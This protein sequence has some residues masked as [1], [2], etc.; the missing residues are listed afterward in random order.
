[1]YSGADVS[2][3]PRPIYRADGRKIPDCYTTPPE[4]RERL[5]T[6]LGRFPL[7]NFWGPASSIVSSRWIAEASRIVFEHHRPTLSL[8]YLPHLDY[9][10]QRLGPGHPALADA[11]RDIDEVVGGLIDFFEAR[12]VRLIILS[13]YG[14]EAVSGDVPI[15]R[16]LREAGGC[17]SGRRWAASCST[18]GRA[19]PLPWPI[20]RWRTSTSRRRTSNALRRSAANSRASSAV[21]D[22][23]EQAAFGL[24]HPRAGE[25]VL[26]AARG[27]WFSYPYWLDDRRAPDFAR[28]V[29]IHRKPGYDPLELLLDPARPL[30][31]LRLAG[32]LLRK[33]L[34]FRGLLDVIPLDSSLVRGSHGR[35]GV[36]PDLQPVLITSAARGL[37]AEELPCTAVRDLV[38]E[39]VFGHG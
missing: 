33:A 2:V 22:R 13:E 11:L 37:D 38:L 36:D 8:I 3:T 34:G 25:L 15:N 1:M 27:R 21:L 31:R 17:R 5:Q 7:F 26:V 32:K 39:E 4:L 28:T 6:Q 18:P 12:N 9:D 35:V 20:T 16:R 14:I 19:T 10:L 29:D 24:D 23:Q 30:I